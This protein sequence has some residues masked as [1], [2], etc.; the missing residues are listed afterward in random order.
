MDSSD[1]GDR[2]ATTCNES[3]P[4]GHD[5][6]SLAVVEHGDGHFCELRLD[7][8]FPDGASVELLEEDE[9]LLAGFTLASDRKLYVVSASGDILIGTG[10]RWKTWKR[11]RVDAILASATELPGHGVL[12]YGLDG[13]IFE[14]SGSGWKACGKGF[15][16]DVHAMALSPRHGILAAGPRGLFARGGTSWKRVHATSLNDLT[17]SDGGEVVAVGP[18]GAVLVS[19]GDG[20]RAIKTAVGR[21]LRATACYA[22]EIYVG[23]GPGGV[24]TLDVARG[25][26]VEVKKT[27]ISDSL[28]A[29]ADYLVAA[30]GAEVAR[31]DGKEWPYTELEYET[32]D[33][34]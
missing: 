9:L 3:I 10:P 18:K 6:I 11:G 12:L 2:V 22:G 21:D 30:G 26:L 4:V 20:W 33:D 28:A 23:A 17:V 34:E 13:A 32:D 1:E 27:V 29:S 8:D 5:L 14:D 19:D 16:G 15:E 31:F 25:K 7:R 24:F